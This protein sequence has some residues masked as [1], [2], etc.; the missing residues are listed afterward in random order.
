[1]DGSQSTRGRRLKK[2]ERETIKKYLEIDE[3][4]IDMVFDRT[5]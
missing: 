5:L 3:L 4:D 1:M 2:T